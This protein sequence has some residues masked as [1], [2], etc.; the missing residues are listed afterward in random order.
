MWQISKDRPLVLANMAAA[1]VIVMVISFLLQGTVLFF[2]GTAIVVLS[3]LPVVYLNYLAKYIVYHNASLRKRV[4]VGEDGELIFPIENQSSLP[5]LNGQVRIEFDEHLEISRF[6]EGKRTAFISPFQLARHGGVTFKVPFKAKKRG[7]LRVKSFKIVI[8]D[9]FKLSSVTLTYNSLLHTEIIIYPELE[10]LVQL[11]DLLLSEGQTPQ[12]ASLFPDYTQ[13]TGTRDYEPSDPLKFVHW[14][15][16]ARMG[17]LQTKTF[18]K[19]S[20]IYWTLIFVLDSGQSGYISTEQL[21]RSLSMAAYMTQFA[22]KHQIAFDFYINIKTKGSPS[23]TY[24]EMG[25]GVQHLIKAWEL[26][27]LADLSYIRIH[28]D[29]A[30]GYIDRQM[31]GPRMI[32]ICLADSKSGYRTYSKAWMKRGHRLYHVK[33]NGAVLGL[34]GHPSPKDKG[35]GEALA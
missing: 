19:V 22:E 2:A 6:S 7:W 4:M 29:H 32:F 30:W 11:K 9:P 1:G 25:Q 34:S 16:S 3:M 23:G 8:Q 17:Q 21:E 24:L 28:P 13:V 33:D 10:P 27:A 35:K 15:A 20:G 12:Q 18:E 5:L 26:L 31:T 14:K